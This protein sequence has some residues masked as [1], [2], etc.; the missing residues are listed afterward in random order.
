M[1]RLLWWS[2]VGCTL[3]GLTALVAPA[4]PDEGDKVVT[5]DGLKSRPPKEWVEQETTS[6][7]RVKQYRLPAAEGDKEPA[8]VVIFY[9]QGQGGSAQDNVKRWKGMFLAPDV[10]KESTFKV[11]DVNVTYLDVSGTYKQS[12]APFNPN[13]KVVQKPNYRM[14]GV[15]FESKNGPYFIRMVGPANTV[16]KYKQGFDDWLKG[17]KAS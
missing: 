11:G 10:A 14:L 2:C 13:A 6:Q 5:L 16:A 15:V 8:E 3:L 17:F 9:F 7:M 4:A 1:K 12:T